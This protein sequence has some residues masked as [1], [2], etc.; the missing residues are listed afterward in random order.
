MHRV[1]HTIRTALAK[2]QFSPAIFLDVSQPFD[3]VQTEGL[4]HKVSQYLPA[5]YTQ[6]L[7]LYLT[8]RT[9][10]IQHGEAILAKYSIRAGVPQGSVLGPV[11]YLLYTADLLQPEKV[12]VATFADN[13]VVLAPNSDWYRH[14]KT[15]N[16]QSVK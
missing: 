6:L 16:L 7:Q 11:L 1:A 4:L 8:N 9:F 2:K 13:T 5:K 12:V 10:C 3:R 14:L 15:Y